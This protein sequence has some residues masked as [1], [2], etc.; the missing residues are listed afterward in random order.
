[1]ENFLQY[2]SAIWPLTPLFLFIIA[3]SFRLLDN[4]TY[5]FLKNDILV[6]TSNVSRRILKSQINSSD[7]ATF[8]KQLKRA[9]LYRNLQQS[10]LIL[11]IVTLPLSFIFYF[12]S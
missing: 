12:L 10:F 7:D 4:S 5:L 9:L 1:M 6:N 2:L 3:V 11:A 8:I